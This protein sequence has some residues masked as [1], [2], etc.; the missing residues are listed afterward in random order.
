MRALILVAALS[1]AGCANLDYAVD[2]YGN[3][4]MVV[5]E[6][7]DHP[8]RVF[9]K[10]QANKIMMTASLGAAMGNGFIRGLTF[11]ILNNNTSEPAMR[12]AAEAYLSSTGRTCQVSPGHLIQEPQWEFRYQCAAIAFN[13]QPETAAE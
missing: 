12:S 1:V 4:P 2:E 8:Y 6:H 10:P 3:T 9:D 7:S 11:G 13:A 5:F